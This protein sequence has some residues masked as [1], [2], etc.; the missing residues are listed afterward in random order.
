LSHDPTLPI[1]YPDV[2]GKEWD[3]TTET[4]TWDLTALFA[5]I[6][7]P[8]IEAHLEAVKERAQ[9]F[10]QSCR[11]RVE[12]GELDA[13]GLRDAL[14]EF[15]AIS[16]EQAKPLSYAHLVFAADT[17]DP[18][19]GAFMQRM[20]ERGTEISLH[21]LFFELELNRAEEAWI[22]RMLDDPA[23][24][25]YRHFVRTVR[26]F[27]EHQLSEPEERLLEEKANTGK[28]AFSRLFEEVTANILFRFTLDGRTESLTQS[29]VLNRLRDARRD[30][31][32]AAAAALSEGLAGN[33]RVLT[34]IFNVLLQEKNVEDRLRRYEYPEQARQIS[35]ELE[36]ETVDLVIRTCVEHYPLVARYYGLKREI[37][38]VDTLTHYDR[39]APLFDTAEEV[40]FE[41]ARA[42]VLDAFGEFSAR[43]RDA[44]DEFFAQRWIDAEPRKGKRGGAF[45][46]YVTPDLHPVVFLNYLNQMDNVMTLAHELGHGVHASLSRRQS[47]LN[48]HGTLPLAELAST[49]AEMLVFERLQEG[50][51]L[52]DRLALYADKIEGAFA[53][54]FRQ[55]ALY[56]FEQAIHQ[57]RRTA[58]ELTPEQYGDLWQAQIQAMF[59]DSVVLGD[60]HRA[61]WIYISHFIGS[62][63]YVY[64]YSFGELLVMALYRMYQTTGAGFADRY[65]ALLEAGGS[66]SPQELM[67]EV[68]IDL[69]D[70][71]FWRGGM[72]VLGGLVARF[73]E[74]WREYQRS[75]QPVAANA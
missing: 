54:I 25:P 37:L 27:R 21:L 46:S 43:I 41:R 70:P 67:A 75:E 53:T 7:D 23:L 9:R 18:R 30:A 16:Q 64:A 50:A 39:Y 11:G 12:K 73:E 6:D 34:F 62:P 49:F 31:R 65:I 22:G 8:A 51:S 58:G 44:A 15:E 17:S 63:F 66:K 72:E 61:W 52:R 55:A 1:R 42:M 68:G 13:P 2:T 69:N 38:G 10:E 60:E 45:C 48:F 14:A 24:A 35:N 4:M 19:H 40:P 5:G 71:A 36:R 3:V 57:Q 32:R 20:R 26:A 47:Y 33:T 29:E 56:R 74:L 28:R 59:G